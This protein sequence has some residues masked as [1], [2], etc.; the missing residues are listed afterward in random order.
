M[1]KAW[2]DRDNAEVVEQQEKMR[3]EAIKKSHKNK[4]RIE[5]TRQLQKELREKFIAVNDF[6]NDCEQ[7][8][9]VLDK[10]IAAEQEIHDKMQKEVDEYE[11]KIKKMTEHHEKTLKPDIEK[12]KVYEDV[13]QQVVDKM[14]IFK[15]KEDFLDRCEALCE[16]SYFLNWIIFC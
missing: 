9:K 13:L 12:G 16:L 14:T 4:K 10:K 6:I 5:K 8:E 1:V 3:E 15:N 2:N 7:K 11:E